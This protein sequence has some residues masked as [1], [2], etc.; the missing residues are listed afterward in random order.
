MGAVK[1]ENKELL[2]KLTVE[3]RERRSAEARLK[4]AQTQAEDQRKLLYQT[5][6]ELATSRQ[7]VLE[8]KAELQKANEVAEAI[9]Q[10]SYALGVEETQARFTEELAEVCRDYCMVSWAKTFNLAG[11][12]ADSKWRQ[13]GNI[14]YHPKIREISSALLSP[15]T[16]A[17]ESLE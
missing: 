9:K 5:E 13:P 3:E 8:L 4:N 16:T 15:S 12:P 14:Y 1:E 17:L 11:V 10:A 2:S 6:I 7:F